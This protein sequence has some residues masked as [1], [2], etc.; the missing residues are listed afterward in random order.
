MNPNLSSAETDACLELLYRG[1]AH[2]RMAAAGGDAERAEAIGDALHNLPRLLSRGDQYGWDLPTFR[3]LFL[4]PLIERYPDLAGLAQ[5][6][7]ALG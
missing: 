5:P 1:L 3:S 4:E 6:L 2:V 7:D